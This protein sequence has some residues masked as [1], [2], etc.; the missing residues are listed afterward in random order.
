V[1]IRAVDDLARES[2]ISEF[3][4]TVNKICEHRMV[5]CTI[6]HK[7]SY[8]PIRTCVDSFFP[9]LVSSK[10]AGSRNLANMV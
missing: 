4:N 1:D 8:Y 10:F 2:I 7:V 6:E 9:T 5:N 3:S